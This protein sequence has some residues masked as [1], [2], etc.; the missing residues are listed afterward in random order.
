[1]ADTLGTSRSRTSRRKQLEAS[2]KKP[3]KK[4]RETRR[5]RDRRQRDPVDPVAVKSRIYFFVCVA[6]LMGAC[7][8]IV[9]MYIRV[10]AATNDLAILRRQL[11]AIEANNQTME[12]TVETMNMDQLYEYAID[13]LGMV[14]TGEDTI[15][16]INVSIQSYTTSNLPVQEISESKVT[17]HWFN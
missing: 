11:N 7:M 5:S 3:E 15:I 4:R 10:F 1:M 12:A 6:F 17:Y 9:L 2:N 14:E 8:I 16:K 13:T